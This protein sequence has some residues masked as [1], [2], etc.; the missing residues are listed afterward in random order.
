MYP[1]TVES[2]VR[3]VVATEVGLLR[4]TD[5]EP[6]ARLAEGGFDVGRFLTRLGLGADEAGAPGQAT[7][8]QM[9]AL[10]EAKPDGV[11]RKLWALATEARLQRL[12]QGVLIASQEQPP[13]DEGRRWW[14]ELATQI[15]WWYARRDADKGVQLVQR[16]M[17]ARAGQSLIGLG[18]LEV[19]VLAEG[20]ATDAAAFVDALERLEYSEQA[21]MGA[22]TA[23]KRIAQKVTQWYGGQIQRALR[24]HAEQMVDSLGRELLAD[25]DDPAFL[26]DAVRGWISLTTGLP[27]SV[28]SPSTAFFVKKFAAAGLSDE[29]L[30]QAADEAGLGLLAV[31][32]A[33]AEFV[34]TLCR[35]CTPEN[36]EHQYCVKQF[37]IMGLQVECPVRPDLAASATPMLY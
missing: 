9:T 6:A 3:A 31:D 14:Y 23:L 20:K 32:G 37:A 8:G 35:N 16:G 12:I 19:D 27:I 7:L 29:T 22:Y 15:L 36:A 5:L 1:T 24:Q 18:L 34:E 4:L 26:R 17:P 28:W 2:D 30:A 10:L 21:A 33:L 11:R 13:A 25:F